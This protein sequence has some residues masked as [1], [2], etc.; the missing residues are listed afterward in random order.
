MNLN[1][2]FPYVVA[3]YL[4]VIGLFFIASDMLGADYISAMPPGKYF[5][6]GLSMIFIAAGVGAAYLRYRGKLRKS[7]KSV[8]EVRL[9]AIENF[10]D[11]ELLV[12][13]AL[14][15]KDVE[16]RKAAEKR[17]REIR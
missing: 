10:K 4:I 17:L 14:E 16:I 7:G 3:C 13:I 15:E 6:Y 11:T 9:E 2:N 8:K 1:R 5:L 12:N